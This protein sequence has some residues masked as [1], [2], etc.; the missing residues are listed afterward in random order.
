MIWIGVDAHKEVHL[1]VAIGGEGT[2]GERK[3]ANTP[4]AWAALLE[5]ARQWPERVWAVEGAW[6]LGRGLAQYLARSG[7]RVHEV[8]GRWTAARRRGM[9]APGK[10]DRLDARSVAT[11]LREEAATLPRVYAEE[12]ALAQVQLWSRAQAELTKDIT[13]TMNRLHE[14]LLQCDP[15]YKTALPVLTTKAAI[16]TLQAYQAPGTSGLDREREALIR[17]TAAQLALLDAQDRE[18]RKKLEHASTARFFPL[19]QIEGVGPIIACAIVAEVGRPRPGFAEE[20]LAALGGLS[21][22]E[23]SSAGAIRHRLNRLGNRRLNMLFHQIVLTQARIYPPARTYLLRRQAEGRTARE[24]R[25]ALKRLIVRRV[26]RAW[27]DCFTARA[28]RVA[29]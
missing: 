1:A 16:T 24:A 5:W 3:I 8:N 15:E 29:A 2:V 17:A 18:L 6:Y 23:A 27:R 14:L 19:R 4:E 28:E 21:P 11:L 10:S 12:D 22:L 20:Q 26:Y 25:R 9:R 7:E 13:R